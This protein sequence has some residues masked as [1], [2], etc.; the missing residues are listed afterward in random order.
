M[1]GTIWTQRR[2]YQTSSSTRPW[3]SEG[4]CAT[5][6][7]PSLS[8]DWLRMPTSPNL[9]EQVRG[10]ALRVLCSVWFPL[11]PNPAAA[12]DDVD[13]RWLDQRS[14]WHLMEGG[15]RLAVVEVAGHGWVCLQVAKQQW[16]M[17]MDEAGL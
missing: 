12:D 2:P 10:Q 6:H 3:M 14:R 15:H 5:V 17:L 4:E 8:P 1:A 16:R 11:A 7:D 9:P 13:S